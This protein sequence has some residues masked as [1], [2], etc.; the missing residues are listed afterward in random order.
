MIGILTHRDR[1]GILDRYSYQY[2]LMGNKTAIEKQRRGLEEESG[3][4]TYGYDA[5]GRLNEVTRNGGTLREYEYDAFGNRSLLREAGGETTYL[6]N[7]LNQLVSR[8]DAV[9]EETYAYDKRGNLNLIM[10]NG[11]LK[12]RYT[13]GAR[14]VWNMR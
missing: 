6:Y 5:L 10:E 2:D 12:N 8:T 4:Y 3:F 13:Y 1:E 11:A 7:A 14:T 9:N